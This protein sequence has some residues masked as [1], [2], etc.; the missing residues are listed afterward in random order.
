MRSSILWRTGV[1]IYVIL[2]VG[3][4]YTLGLVLLTFVAGKL[5]KKGTPVAAAYPDRQNENYPI[6]PDVDERVGVDVLRKIVRVT[7][8]AVW[9]E[10]GSG[11]L[12]ILDLLNGG[13]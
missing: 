4:F 11:I 12:R 8:T 2:Q 7:V 10:Y 6:I 3:H 13:S 5:V 1:I 9:R